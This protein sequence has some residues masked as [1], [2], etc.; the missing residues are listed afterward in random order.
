[1]LRYIYDPIGAPENSS[2]KRCQIFSVSRW[3]C[4]PRPEFVN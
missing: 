4:G 1:L 2:G 3:N